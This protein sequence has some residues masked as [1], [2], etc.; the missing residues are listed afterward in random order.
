MVF[1][2]LLRRQDRRNRNDQRCHVGIK[3]GG[4]YSIEPVPVKGTK[5][6]EDSLEHL[7][8]TGYAVLRNVVD[9]GLVKLLQKATEPCAELAR[10][11]YGPDAQRLQPLGNYPQLDLSGLESLR[12]CRKLRQGVNRLLGHGFGFS[13]GNPKTLGVLLEPAQ[14]TQAMVLHRDWYAFKPGADLVH[15]QTNFFNPRVLWQFNLALYPDESLGIVPGSHRYLD[16]AAE[17]ERSGGPRFIAVSGSSDKEEAARFVQDYFYGLWADPGLQTVKLQP[18]DLVIYRATMLHAAQ[19]DTGQKRRTIHDFFDTP[20]FSEFRAHQMSA[21]AAGRSA[22][23]KPW[24]VTMSEAD[25][26]RY[27]VQSA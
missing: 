15:L 11:A 2:V 3:Q 24:W 17:V 6:T 26:A 8:E 9:S 16:L 13:Y 18:G 19:Y 23:A 4:N 20:Q 7:R 21:W 1:V 10:Q 27:S 5:M 12:R 22:E 14:T 25:L